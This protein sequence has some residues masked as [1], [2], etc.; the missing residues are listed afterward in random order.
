[1]EDIPFSQSP[2]PP[3]SGEGIGEGDWSIYTVLGR[4]F[5]VHSIFNSTSHPY[6][7][8]PYSSQPSIRYPEDSA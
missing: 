6:V 8:K 2:H 3:S 7:G 1:M 4:Y 5:A